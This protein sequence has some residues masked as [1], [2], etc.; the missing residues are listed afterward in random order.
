[1]ANNPL[2][3]KFGNSLLPNCRGTVDAEK[4]AARSTAK[5]APRLNKCYIIH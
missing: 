4:G 5:P 1:M 3:I 2:T